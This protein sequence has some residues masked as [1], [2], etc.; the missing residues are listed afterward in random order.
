MTVRG[1]MFVSLVVVTGCSSKTATDSTGD[2]PGGLAARIKEQG[3]GTV[4]SASPTDVATCLQNWRNTVCGQWCTRETQWDRQQCKNFLD[5]Y[6]NNGCG[7]STCGRP[8]DVCGVNKVKPGAGTAPKIIA[9]QVYQ[10]LACPGSTPVTSCSNP[11]MPDTTP[12][13]D[14]NACTEGDRC[15]NR[16]CVSGTPKTCPPPDVCHKPGVCNQ[17]TGAC[18]YESKNNGTTC[19]DGNLCTQG[20]NCQSGVCQGNPVTCTALDQCHVAGTCSPVTGLCNNPAKAGCTVVPTSTWNAAPATDSQFGQ[21]VPMASGT[22]WAEGRL[23]AY[24]VDAAGNA[25]LFGPAAGKPFFIDPA[26]GAYVGVVTNGYFVIYDAAGTE[27]LNV[28][29]SPDSSAT[30]VP[31]RAIAA[32]KYMTGQ[33]PENLFVSKVRFV[34]EGYD[35][36]INVADFRRSLLT[37]DY[38][39]FTTSTDIRVHDYTGAEVNRY[40]VAADLMAASTGSKAFAFVA[41]GT[42]SLVYTRL[43]AGALG[44]PMTLDSPVWNLALSSDGRFMVATTSQSVYLFLD[45]ALVNTVPLAVA[46]INSADVSDEGLVVLGTQNSDESTQLWSVG[47]AGVKG[48]TMARSVK[49]RRAYHPDVHFVPGGHGFLSSERNGISAFTLTLIP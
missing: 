13:R 27:Q 8:D 10:C 36:N 7:P 3:T 34:G 16:V 44:T 23:G 45:G 9:D 6:Q 25:V 40:T 17:G 39:V 5:C 19:D 15:Q 43:P 49:D 2:S 1:L 12:C 33:D 42:K 26:Y 46:Y 31:G 32:M 18:S 14:G 48:F 41:H 29:L 11:P 30:V 47:S 37:R 28:Q 21:V 4:A 20:D 35:A 22:T 38:Y 24:R